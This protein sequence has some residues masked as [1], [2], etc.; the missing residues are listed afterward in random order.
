MNQKTVLVMGYG[1]PI[2]GDDGIGERVATE[3]ENWNFS[4]VR[5]QSLHQL[6]PEVAEDL[7]QVDVVIF[8]DASI[9]GETVEL[10]AVEPL[11][12]TELNW[13]HYLNPQSLL[14]LAKTL[15]HKTPEAWLISVPGVDFELGENL[16]EIAKQ[17]VTVALEKIK[18]LIS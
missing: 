10:L 13:G 8:V 4:N 2:R 9:T 16:S 6:V 3:V 17:G 12:T 1:N 7:T 15:Y 5:S 14:T 18:Q 11:E